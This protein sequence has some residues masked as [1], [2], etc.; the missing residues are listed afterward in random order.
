MVAEQLRLQCLYWSV[1]AHSLTAGDLSDSG[2]L[3]A[4]TLEEFPF[5][6]SR[7]SFL[8]PCHWSLWTFLKSEGFLICVSPSDGGCG[9]AFAVA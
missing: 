1:L 4:V 5:Q 3:F 8:R 9:L 6:L 2:L 7:Y